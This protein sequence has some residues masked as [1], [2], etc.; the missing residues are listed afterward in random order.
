[1]LVYISHGVKGIPIGDVFIIQRAHD[2][3][4]LPFALTVLL[5]FMI[6]PCPIKCNLNLYYIFSIK[7]SL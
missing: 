4:T 1:M 5:Y 6:Y 3:S 2:I 7:L